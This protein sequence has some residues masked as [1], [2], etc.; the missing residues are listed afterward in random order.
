MLGCPTLRFQMKDLRSLTYPAVAPSLLAADPKH[1][2]LAVAL[3]EKAGVPFLHIDV[4]DGHFVPATSFGVSFVK[5]IAHTHPL[6]NDVH[7]MI[8]KP[9][10]SALS[11]AA[12]GADILTFHWEAC[13]D[14]NKIDLTLSR[15][16]EA[17][18][19]AGLSIKPLTPISA[20]EPYLRKVDIILLMSVEPGK[21]GQSFLPESLVRVAA[22]RQKIDALPLNERPL[23]EVDGGLNELTGPSV[24]KAGADI[25]VAGS[26]L[27][28]HPDFASRV[29]SLL[30]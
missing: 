21:G 22:L 29:R 8:E 17:S 13:P 10:E 20:V 19:R 3:A 14:K 26:F 24:I 27:F 6:V 12:A 23:L 16:H 1:M 2:A 7:L 18:V 30:E 25:L 4:M 15:L 9:W 28:G 5:S 11:F